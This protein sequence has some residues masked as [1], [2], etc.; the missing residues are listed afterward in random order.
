MSKSLA[1]HA[2][3]VA[4]CTRS[5]DRGLL[6]SRLHWNDAT[7]KA[8]D[9]RYADPLSAAAKANAK[10]LERMAVDLERALAALRG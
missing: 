2:S 5:L 6:S 3:N 4:E 9:K 10:E 7:R 1:S 8:F